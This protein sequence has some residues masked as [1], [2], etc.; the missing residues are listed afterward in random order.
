[1]RIAILSASYP[2]FINELYAE[3]PGLAEASYAA[4]MQARNDSLFGFADFYSRGFIGHGHEAQEFHFNNPWI[5]Y[6]WMR[7]RGLPTPP[8]EHLRSERTAAPS[9]LKRALMPLKPALAPM[10]R[11]LRPPPQLPAW[12][13]DILRAQIADY[14]PDLILNQEPAKLRSAFLKSL[15]TQA[16]IIGQIASP[17][18]QQE[19][20]SAYALMISSLPNFITWFRGH[21]IPAAF[22]K[23]SFEARIPR[24]LGERPR[25]IPLSF[26]GN[27]SSDHGERLVWLEYLVQHTP[28]EIWGSGIERVAKSSPLHARHRGEAWGRKMYEILGRSQLTLNKH[29]DLAEGFANNLRLYEATGMGAALLTD[30]KTNLGDIF[31]PQEVASYTTKE[32]CARQITH[33]LADPAACTA[34]ARA[35]QQRT[36]DDHNY[37]H[38]TGEML[39]L[40]QNVLEGRARRWLDQTPE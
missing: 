6:A 27:I 3:N 13:D 1:M 24:M 17:L 40:L 36:L 2:N 38:R 5:Q 39:E 14:K 15:P 11:K 4:Q 21:G 28:L 35:G 34:M 26:V 37:R 30:A 10:L 25:D 23:L 18:P 31:T 32:D 22:N 8:D 9:P 29:I 12:Q 7:E 20:F 19:D 16:P 33:L